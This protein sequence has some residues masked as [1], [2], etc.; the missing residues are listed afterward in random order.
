MAAKENVE[1]GKVSSIVLEEMFKN[2]PV[3]VQDANAGEK[4]KK[5]VTLEEEEGS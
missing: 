1:L 3:P 4:E 2:A 5:T